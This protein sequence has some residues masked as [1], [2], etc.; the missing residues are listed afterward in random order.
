MEL[1]RT[2]RW[3][4]IRSTLSKIS[5]R[6][7]KI[8]ENIRQ[9]SL[10]FSQHFAPRHDLL[11]PLEHRGQALDVADHVHHLSNLI[12]LNQIKSD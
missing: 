10:N 7:V 6:D 3:M 5:V 4:D 11:G 9:I 8:S 2:C 12:R 1:N